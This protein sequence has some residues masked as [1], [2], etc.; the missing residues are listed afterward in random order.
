[1]THARIVSL[2]MLLPPCDVRLTRLTPV[3]KEN[4]KE[5]KKYRKT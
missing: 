1:M 5:E 3:T 2:L 4:S